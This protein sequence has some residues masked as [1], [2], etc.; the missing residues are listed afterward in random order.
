MGGQVTLLHPNGNLDMNFF[1]GTIARQQVTFLNIVPS[2][3][4]ILISHLRITNNKDCLKTI[5]CI[6][7]QSKK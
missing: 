3:L 6:S 4:A 5:R 1:S 2:L 7:S